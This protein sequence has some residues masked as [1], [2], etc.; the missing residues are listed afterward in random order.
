[1]KARAALAGAGGCGRAPAAA[2][3]EAAPPAPGLYVHVPFCRRVCPYCDFAVAPLGGRAASR[4]F[5]DYRE[6]LLRE[7]QLRAETAAGSAGGGVGKPA[8]TVYFGGGTPSLAPPGFF[9]EVLETAADLELTTP[10]PW[11]VLEANPED[12]APGESPTRPSDAARGSGAAV[13]GEDRARQWAAEGVAGVSLG[14]QALRPDRLRFLGRAHTPDAVGAAAARLAA[15]GIPWISLDL[16]YG[17]RGDDPDGIAAEFADAAALPG[18]THLSA[19]ELTVEPGTPFGRRAAA[20]ESL[21]GGSDLGARLFRAVHRTLADAGFPAYEASNFAR[22]PSDRSRHN[23]KYWLGAAYLGVGPS[24]HSFRPAVAVGNARPGPA[25]RSWNHRDIADWRSAVGAGR[26]PAAGSEDL[27]PAALALEEVF[28]RLRM[29]DGLD[30]AGFADRCGPAVV[31][32]NRARFAGWRDRGLVRFDR[33]PAGVFLRPTL[34]GLA[35]ADSLAAEVDLS[36]LES[37]VE[38][39]LDRPGRSGLDASRRRSSPALPPP[40]P[41]VTAA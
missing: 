19:Y 22:S 13:P 14:A 8:D 37:P 35:V 34:D 18:V 28:L 20:G 23:R 26:L 24:A 12:L 33:T 31:E 6:A 10:A 30:L 41:A 15:A 4:R 21:A 2:L 32:G 11:V 38:S 39:P 29:T 25:R 36:P 7:L 9:A 16:I 27:P 17:V 40:T 1:M 5:A 3:A